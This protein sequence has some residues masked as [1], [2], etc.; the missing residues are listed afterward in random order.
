MNTIIPTVPTVLSGPIW[1]DN[2]DCHSGVDV[3]D[4]C[5][6]NGWGDHNCR[7]NADIGVICLK[8]MHVVSAMSVG[9]THIYLWL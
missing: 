5:D 3:L 4:D 1:M 8:G 2:V 6:F 7:H 9:L